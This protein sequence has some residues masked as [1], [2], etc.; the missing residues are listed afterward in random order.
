MFRT[1]GRVGI[2]F[3]YDDPISFLKIEYS[4]R[5]VIQTFPRAI[6]NNSSVSSR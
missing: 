6:M 4:A 1:D 5:N 2:A 3:G